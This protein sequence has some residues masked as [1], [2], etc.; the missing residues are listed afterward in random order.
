MTNKIDSSISAKLQDCSINYNY[1]IKM[2]FGEEYGVDKD[3][4]LVIQFSPI[5]PVQKGYMLNNDKLTTNVKNFISEFEDNLSDENIRSQ[6]YAYRLLFTL[7]SANRRGQADQVIEFIGEGTEGSEELNK[8]YTLIKE[9]EKKKY[10]GKEIIELMHNKG[11]KWFTANKMT[12]IWKYDLGGREKYGVYVTPDQWLWYENWIPVVEDYCKCN[13]AYVD[14]NKIKEGYF[15]NEIVSL[16]INKGYEKFTMKMFVGI[17]R[18][19]MHINQNDTEYG[20][21]MKNKRFVWREAFIKIVEE[22]CEN[23]KNE[24]VEEDN[25]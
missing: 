4:G 3:L 17:W 25:I 18:D 12:E 5:T 24:L 13:D 10:R 23:H 22:Y 1:Y 15:A 11:Y 2:L 14:E 6:K 21:F 8:A 7:L 9:T 20:Y 16:M 19:E